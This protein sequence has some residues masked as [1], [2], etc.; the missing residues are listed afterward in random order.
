MSNEAL[1]EALGIGWEISGGKVVPIISLRALT[2]DGTELS[3]YLI[4]SASDWNTLAT[5]SASDTYSGKYFKLTADISVTT[6]VGTD[7][8]RFAGIFDGNGHTLEFTKG[9]SGSPYSAEACAPFS[10]IRGATIKRL[11]VIGTIYTSNQFAGMVGRARGTGTCSIS[12]CRSSLNIYASRDGDG[13]QGGILGLINDDAYVS[14][15]NC[16]FDGTLSGAST[17]NC[18][19]LVGWSGGAR[20]SISN[21][22]F[23]PADGGFGFNTTGSNTISR[24]A[25][26]MDIANCYCKVEVNSDNQATNA[27]GMTNEQLLA[28]LGSGWTISG[29]K[30]VPAIVGTPI[31]GAVAKVDD[32]YY[33]SFADAL[34]EWTGGATLTL[35]ADIAYASPITVDGKIVVLDLNGHGIRHTGSEGVFCIV[36]GADFT[37]NDSNPDTEHRFSID[38]NGFATLDEANGS[39][40][41][42]GGYITGGLGCGNTA[43]LNPGYKDGGAFFLFDNASMTMNAGT[44]IGNGETINNN[45][46]GGAVFITLGSHFIMNGGTITRN[47]A[48]YGGGIS[49]YG[50]TTADISFNAPSVLEIHGGEI[51]YNYATGNSGGVHT[52]ARSCNETVYITGGS[53]INNRVPENQNAAG[54]YVEHTGTTVHMSGN[55]V[56]KDNYSGSVQKGL[57]LTNNA[58]LRFDGDMTNTEPIHIYMMATDVPFTNGL[59]THAD[60][61]NFVSDNPSYGV[62]INSSGEAI[63]AQAAGISAHPAAIN[64]TYTG[65]AQTLVTA[66]TAINGTMAYSLDR[67]TWSASTP[68]ATNA[69][70]Y[71]VYYRV[72]GDD[73]HGDIEPNPNSVEVTIAK[74]PLTIKAE[75]SQ[76]VYGD[77][78]WWCNSATYSGFV[79]GES[80][81]VLDGAV[82]FNNEYHDGDDVGTY[83]NM[84]CCVT[85]ANYDI[86]FVPGT[87]TVSKAA[88][89]TTAPASMGDLAYTAADQELVN[90]G[91]G[92]GGEWQYKVNSGDYSNA[93]PTGKNVGE[94]TVYYKFVGDA[95]HNNIDEAS[96]TMQ[97][98]PTVVAITANADPEHPEIYY[99]T[100]YYQTQRYALPND[101]TKAFVA[102]LIGTDLLMHEI[103]SGE[104]VIPEDVAVILQSPVSTINMTLTDA[105]PVTVTDPNCL[106]GTDGAKAAPANC[107]VISGHSTD[108]NVVG[109]GFYQ[110]SGTLKAHKAFTT[111]PG[112]YGAA[113][114]RMRFVFNTTTGMDQITNDKSPITN[115][116]IEDGVLYIIKNGVKY[117]AQGQI[118]K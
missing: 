2:G 85:A 76:L 93:L 20:S 16:L 10:F 29:S 116:V 28:A 89:V 31:V 57:Q 3:P 79:N 19:G 98:T 24:N 72:V 100:F 37:L 77:P 94:Y 6:M 87:V 68:Q 99:S 21:C 111:Y 38:E 1:Q 55:P 53:I 70:N 26:N 12:R 74:A 46:T 32:F 71:T 59:G 81:T 86:T 36:H 62:K 104:D 91:S 115:K 66:G 78:A 35:L 97:I 109:V 84:P 101:G 106:L 114:K 47:R 56:I 90:A 18:G 75:D 103:A 83:Q 5:N 61:S 60:A 110:F 95:N 118:V 22:L 73:T 96:F 58:T 27:S 64:T 69:G 82:Q 13:K 14:I 4:A 17:N 45:R 51:S 112:G 44:L 39:L 49:L 113:P 63:M 25:G 23:A 48:R 7:G 33:T 50:S 67:I 30:V 52:N 43:Y 102:E 40:T 42:H 80:V 117:N 15:S 8:S 34:A 107:Y 108:N 9:T 65:V 11:H 88:P 54:M 105:D 92:T 41:I